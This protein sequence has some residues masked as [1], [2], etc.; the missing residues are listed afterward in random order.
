MRPPLGVA[1]SPDL[2][3]EKMSELM[4]G[5]KS[6]QT[7]LDDLLVITKNSV[8]DHLNKLERVLA[9]LSLRQGSNLMRLS[10]LSAARV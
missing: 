10:A 5:L 3:Q 9:R 4:A 7:Y 1:N 2:F 6:V 8:E